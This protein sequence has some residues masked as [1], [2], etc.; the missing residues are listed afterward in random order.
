MDIIYF[1]FYLLPT[2]LAVIVIYLI[3]CI[4]RRKKKEIILNIV[5]IA[6]ISVVLIVYYSPSDNILEKY[7]FD[8]IDIDSAIK[9]D[10]KVKGQENI[11]KILKVINKH[12]FIRSAVRT[13]EGERFPGDD[14]IILSMHDTQ[15]GKILHLYIL[16]EHTEKDLLQINSQMYNVR[17]KEGLSKDIIDVLKESSIWN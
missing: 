4:V 9:P 16:N 6:V 12:T 10:V 15:K 13:V 8:Y 1:L 2:I 11:N 5:A 7:N 17:D 3:I 14:L